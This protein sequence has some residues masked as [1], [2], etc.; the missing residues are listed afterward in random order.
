MTARRVERKCLGCSGSVPG[1][2]RLPSFF[3]ASGA[4]VDAVPVARFV[5]HHRPLTRSAHASP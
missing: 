2:C 3:V 4:E 5:V 1:A